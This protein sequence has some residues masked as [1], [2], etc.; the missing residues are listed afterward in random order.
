MG[1][2]V[3]G[4]WQVD[5]V[6]S[7][8][9]NGE[10]KRQ[11]SVFRDRVE[12]K[13]NAK[14]LPEKDRYHLYVSYACPWAHRTLIVRALKGLED[15]VPVS[16]VSPRM[17]ENGWSFIDEY[18]G[19]ILDKVNGANFIRDLYIKADPQVNGKATV[20]VFWDK[21]TNSI[22]SN[23]SAEIIR[24]LNSEFN[25]LTSNPIDL[26]PEDYHSQIDDINAY[27]YDRV[28]N[29]VYKT[30]FATTQEAYEKNVRALFEALDHLELRLRDSDY[31]V[32]D[33]L[34]EADV[35]LFT[36]L[37]RFD[38]VYYSHFKCNLKMLKD[39]PNLHR[40]TKNIY[41]MEKVKPTV[42][43]DHIK[44][45]YYYSQ[46]SINPTGVVPLGPENFYE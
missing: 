9:V 10:F 30:G 35:R 41:N 14:Y 45:H 12:N 27:V 32:G 38:I 26:Y 13:A 1:T 11:N 39:Y 21:K 4:K 46:R 31:L 23:E 34:T 42:N 43:F 6:N 7:S 16:V 15:I 22:V 28:N 19:V 18:P 2:L 37:I 8:V 44:V 24:F 29:G 36:T 33:S 40:F 5:S 25:S 20:P 17:M 3:E